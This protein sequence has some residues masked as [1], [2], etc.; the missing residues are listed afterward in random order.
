[1]HISQMR[2]FVSKIMKHTVKSTKQRHKGKNDGRLPFYPRFRNFRNGD[3]WYGNF[4]GKVPENPEIVKFSKSEPFNQKFRKFRAKSQM[5]RKFPGKMFRKFWYTS[6]GC[7]LFQNLCKL[8]IFY[9]ALACSF[10]CH[11]SELDISFK[12]DGDAGAKRNS[13]EPLINKY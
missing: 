6:R 8:P 7:S 2:L 12:D 5:E 11:H 10:G 13:L 4:L 3:K 1:M 9:S